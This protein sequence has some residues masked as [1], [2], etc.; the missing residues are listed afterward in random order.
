M[1]AGSRRDLGDSLVKPLRI[2]FAG[3]EV[4]AEVK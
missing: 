2:P 4:L 3:T 1:E